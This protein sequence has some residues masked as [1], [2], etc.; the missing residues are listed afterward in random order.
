[1]AVAG[2]CDTALPDG[3]TTGMFAWHKRG[4]EIKRYPLSKIKVTVTGKK[5]LRQKKPAFFTVVKL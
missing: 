5:L 2:F 1:M 4:T 3:A